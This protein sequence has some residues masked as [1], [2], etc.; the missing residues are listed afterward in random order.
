MIRNYFKIAF[1]NLL[2]NKLFSVINILGMSISIACVLT[3]ALFVN[4]E[5]KYDQ[6]IT[7][8]DLKFRIYNTRIPDN[9]AAANVAVVPY[10][11]ATYLQ[12]DYPEIET[13]IRMMDTFG[14]NLFEVGETR[15][16]ERLG[17][18]TEPGIVDLLSLKFISGDPVSALEKPNA[19]VLTK[20]LADKYFQNRPVIGE[21]IKISKVDYTVTG[22]I[23]DVPEHAHLPI[24]YLL[25]FSTRTKDFTEKQTENWLFQQYYTYLKFHPGTDVSSFDSKLLAFVE[26]YAYPKIKPEGMIYIPHLQNIRDIYLESSDFQWDIAK[27]GNAQMVNI[28]VV[29]AVLILIIA[30]LNFINLSTARSIRRMK[31]VGVRKVVGA[32]KTQLIMQFVIESVVLTILGLAVAVAITELVLPGL[33][34]FTEKMIRDPFTPATTALLV[35]GCVLLGILA[36]SYPAF[37][38][39][40]FRPA[41]I[42]ANKEGRSGGV[43]FLRKSLVVLQFTFSFFLIISA[44]IVVSQNDLLRNKDMGF[45]KEQLVVVTLSR[46]QMQKSAAMKEQYANHPNVLDATLSFGLPGDIFPGDGVI[47][48]QSGKAWT[49]DMFIVDE[50]YIKTMDMKMAAGRPFSKDYPSDP[51][52]AFILNET[53]AKAFGFNSPEEALGKKLNWN[54]WGRDTLKR[55]EVIGV[56]KDFHMRSLREKVAPAVMHIHSPYFWTLTMRVKPDGM[57]ETLAHFKSTWE[58]AEDEWPFNYKFLDENFD[59]MYKNE[60]KLSILLSWFTGFAI[61]IACLGLFGLVEYSVNQRAKEISIR[62]VFGAGIPALLILLTRRYLL[63]IL[64]AFAIVIPLSYYTSQ[65]WLKNFAYRIDISPLIFLKAALLILSIT[66][67]TVIFQSLKAATTNPAHI[68]KNE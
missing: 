49:S 12:K 45:D 54:I 17:Y 43:E 57:Q 40:R 65:E 42:F 8:S 19:V 16:Q 37:Q 25:S 11:F 22:V 3:I 2:K 23:E 56:V 14:E 61:F 21:T 28:L 62:K 18:Y 34:T 53:A 38:L 20:K 55:G 15:T 48:P 50:D 13:I 66:F 31:E 32:Y 64:I 24:N 59:N 51:Y 39:S 58:K 6:H 52:S 10:P 1:R 33:N 41:M 9:D 44:F 35:L 7:D 4:D 68:L 30:C 60:E 29:T 46:T 27:H 47:D 5:L 67:I 36:G 63:L 26:K